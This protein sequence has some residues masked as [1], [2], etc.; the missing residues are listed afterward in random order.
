MATITLSVPDNLKS[1]MDKV[2]II[3]WSSV[4]RQAFTQQIE[5]ILELQ[6]IKKIREIS[7][8]AKDDNREV[9]KDYFEKL[10]K[11]A[12][13]PHKKMTIEDLDRMIS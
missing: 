13:G 4:A 10:K 2:T 6:K 1:Q 7:E 5:D 11:I 8:I 12:K 9:K 3:N